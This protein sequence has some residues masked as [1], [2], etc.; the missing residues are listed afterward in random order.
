VQATAHFGDFFNIVN[1]FFVLDCREP[2]D[3]ETVALRQTLAACYQ[4]LRRS[5]SAVPTVCEWILRGLPALRERL[6]SENKE[7]IARVEDLIA[8]VMESEPIRSAKLVAEKE[9][10]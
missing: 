3:S 2:R 1:R 8:L 10:H 7:P 9:E 6:A 5:A 4:Q